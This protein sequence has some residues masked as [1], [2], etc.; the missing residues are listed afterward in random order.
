MTTGLDS[1]F[2]VAVDNNGAVSLAVKVTLTINTPSDRAPIAGND[3]Y[4]INEDERLAVAL[5]SGVTVND[6]DDVGI[7]S[8]ELSDSADH[9]TI[10]FSATGAFSYSQPKTFSEATSLLT[11]LWTPTARGPTPRSQQ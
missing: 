11:P 2:Y 10:V 8:V 9:G 5:D 4:E 3:A 7:V 1:F 6:S